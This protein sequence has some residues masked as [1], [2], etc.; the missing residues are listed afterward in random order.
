MQA[1]TW[2]W[3]KAA[4][5]T[6]M[7][8]RPEFGVPRETGDRFVRLAVLSPETRPLSEEAAFLPWLTP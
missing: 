2:S 3:Q 5:R 6:G 8:C 4:S 1:R 7:V